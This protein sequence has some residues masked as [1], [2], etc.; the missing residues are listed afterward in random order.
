MTARR[1]RA[2]NMQ[3]VSPSFPLNSTIY[4]RDTHM[5]S[6][7]Y[8]YTH[9]TLWML[10]LTICIITERFWPLR[11]LTDEGLQVQ[12]PR[13]C[14][15]NTNCDIKYPASASASL[16]VSV[17]ASPLTVPVS[18]LCRSFQHTHSESSQARCYFNTHFQK[19]NEGHFPPPPISHIFMPCSLFP[20]NPI[21]PFGKAWPSITVTLWG[22]LPPC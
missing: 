11:I 8:A 12:V 6:L 1:H 19:M 15:S 21:P 2:L 20:P 9:T 5:H 10:L 3:D 14:M 22:H 4:L 17:C 18:L 13:I 16:L 7:M